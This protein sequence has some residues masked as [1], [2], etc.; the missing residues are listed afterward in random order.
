MYSVVMMMAM[1]GAPEMPAFGRRNGCDGGCR[2]QATSCCGYTDNCGCNGGRGGRRHRGCSGGCGGYDAGCGCCGNNNCCAQ[3][4]CGCCGQMANSCNSCNTCNSC[5]SCSSC[6][7]AAGCSSCGGAMPVPAS[8]PAP[9]AMPP[10][11]GKT[12]A[13]MAAPAALVVALPADASLKINGVATSQA[14]DV[15]QF[16][17]PTIAGGQN[18]YYT[19]SA[20]IVRNGQTLTSVQ[21]VTVRAGE[22]TS[23]SMP[24]DQFGAVVAMK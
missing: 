17:T 6:G 13:M 5:N 20:E 14:S 10:K 2:G 1:T 16:A 3:S 15:R 4:S 19:L 8:T 9:P 11:D 22:T 7:G 21:T 18:F 12:T 24:V 23:V